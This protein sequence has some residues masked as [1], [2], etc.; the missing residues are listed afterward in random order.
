MRLNIV[1]TV[2]LGLMGCANKIET[3]E[4]FETEFAL[5]Q[6]HAYRQCNRMVFD[7]KYGDMSVCQEAIYKNLREENQSLF[8]DCTF[9]AIAAEECLQELNLSTCGELW[10]N[11]QALYSACHEDVWACQ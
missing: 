1:Y 2:G 9:N 6:C 7:G 8:E 4:D 3:V 5:S 10:T 11:E